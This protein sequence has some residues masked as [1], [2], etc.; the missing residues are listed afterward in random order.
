MA[1][2]TKLAQRMKLNDG[3]LASTSSKGNTGSKKRKNI[4]PR[5]DRL[6]FF[7][8]YGVNSDMSDLQDENK[9]ANASLNGGSS[10][11]DATASRRRNQLDA[12]SGNPPTKKHK[13]QSSSSANSAILNYFAR[14]PLSSQVN[15]IQNA[16]ANTLE[17]RQ[18]LREFSDSLSGPKSKSISAM[19]ISKNSGDSIEIF[20]E[21]RKAS[22]PDLASEPAF[23][24]ICD[25]NDEVLMNKKLE[26][27]PEPTLATASIESKK[28]FVQAVVLHNKDSQEVAVPVEH[29]SDTQLTT[30][31]LKDL[32]ESNNTEPQDEEEGADCEVRLVNSRSVLE[33]FKYNKP[34]P[35]KSI[36]T[37]VNNH[38]NIMHDMQESANDILISQSVS[39]EVASSETTEAAGIVVL[40]DDNNQA[41]DPQETTINQLDVIEEANEQ[42]PPQPPRRRRLMRASDLK[43][44]K[45]VEVSENSSNEDE[46]AKESRK[47]RQ[48]K[49]RVPPKPKLEPSLET[50]SEPVKETVQKPESE[51]E[52]EQEPEP[53]PEHIVASRQFMRSYFGVQSSISSGTTSDLPSPISASKEPKEVSP[54]LESTQLRPVT[55][56]VLKTYSKAKAVGSS[57]KKSH[58][59]DPF[60]DSE[61]S[62]T[63][64]SDEFDDDIFDF[65]KVE[66]PDPNQKSIASMFS[67]DISRSISSYIPTVRPR[68]K[69]VLAP[70]S[71]ATL[72]GG[73]SNVSNTCYLNSV[74][75]TLRNT[76]ECT[77]GLFDIQEKMLEFEKSLQLEIKVSEY[78]RTLFD[79]ALDVFRLLNS[80]EMND[81]VD[82]LDEK[83]IYPTKVILTLRQFDDILK[84]VIQLGQQSESKVMEIKD[85]QPIN[86]LFQ[87]G[88]QTVT[89]CQ[90]CTSVS[91]NVDR[92]I[93]LTVQIDTENPN[94][95]RDLDWG[96]STTMEMEHMKDDNQRFCETCNS[97]E[98]AH[99]YHFFTS[100]PKLMILRLQRYNF[101]EGAVKIQNGVSCTET[102]EFSKLKYNDS[103]VDPV[104][105]EEMARI[106]SGGDVNSQPQSGNKETSAFS[107]TQTS[108][109]LEAGKKEGLGSNMFIDDDMATP[110]VYM[111]RRLDDVNDS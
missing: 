39:T 31:K 92:G 63:D 84:A 43:L 59:R 23:V 67:K 18:P 88:T 98:D 62:G 34:K 109:A 95:I 40:D 73:L 42:E 21:Q 3:T 24:T 10:S 55:K 35:T 33:Y 15:S 87:V 68:R 101:K 89:H 12:S 93:D 80:R 9:E 103:C 47:N 29:I 58:K 77:Q 69:R 51:P 86:D 14:V 7:A 6:E 45:Y 54:S 13:P 66:K 22:V 72:S 78:Q 90:R 36:E 52:S 97:K 25:D 70:A 17:S 11:K 102:L 19:S 110:Y 96:I 50:E 2:T 20:R 64:G 104:S 1:E 71:R 41:G 75:Q 76:V 28:T 85:W 26:P 106:F 16:A 49:K 107:N 53:E 4:G 32:V 91:V 5:G 27:E 74:L 65:K 61:K 44:K 99:V 79:H 94:L 56:P 38:T 81:E 100:L 82:R 8:G 57:K 111:Y 48:A 37:Q 46:P 105:N 30:P 108:E 60:S 83:S